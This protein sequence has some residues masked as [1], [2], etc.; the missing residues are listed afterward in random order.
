MTNGM[1]LAPEYEVLA[2]QEEHTMILTLEAG[3]A[4]AHPEYR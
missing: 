3:G 2:S 4:K 1:V